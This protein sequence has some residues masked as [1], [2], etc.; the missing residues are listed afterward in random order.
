MSDELE[1]KS[2]LF[3]WATTMTAV[4]FAMLAGIIILSYN[5]IKI[6]YKSRY[7]TIFPFL[8]TKSFMLFIKKES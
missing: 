7:F 5:L 3:I 2:N 8:L 4:C 1:E 6:R